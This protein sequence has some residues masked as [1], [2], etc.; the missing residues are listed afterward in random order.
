MSCQT[1]SRLAVPSLFAAFL[2]FCLVLSGHAQSSPTN[3]NKKTVGTNGQTGTPN[4]PLATSRVI[5]WTHMRGEILE[6]EDSA[7][8][9]LHLTEFL[10]KE[11][12]RYPKILSTTGEKPNLAILLQVPTNGAKIPPFQNLIKDAYD[13]E[14]QDKKRKGHLSEFYYGSGVRAGREKPIYVLPELTYGYNP[15]GM[16]VGAAEFLESGDNGQT[17]T[18]LGLSAKAEVTGRTAKLVRILDRISDDLIKED[19]VNTSQVLNEDDVDLLYGLLFFPHGIPK[20]IKDLTPADMTTL[21]TALSNIQAAYTPFDPYTTIESLSTALLEKRVQETKSDKPLLDPLTAV[22]KDRKEIRSKL[23]ND[24]VEEVQRP[25]VSLLLGDHLD[26]GDGS[27]L[28]YGASASTL[29]VYRQG[30]DHAGVT[31]LGVVQRFEDHLNG[32]PRRSAV[33]TGAALIYQDHAPYVEKDAAAD[34]SS[35][36]GPDHASSYGTDGN[37]LFG[38]TWNYKLGLEYTAPMLGLKETYAEF[39]RYRNPRSYF[40]ITLTAGKDGLRQDYVNVS[41]GQ[42]FTF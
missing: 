7:N 19:N 38:P 39:V 11:L 41:L 25:A 26:N 5:D 18:S 29:L 4:L 17:Q 32:D 33:R 12:I 28:D 16:E 8:A 9:K 36:L 1:F 22:A 31:A 21:M 40:E 2:L 20:K 27:L 37:K 30:E 13:A 34:D 6:E 23:L 24:Y 14:Q 35:T 42:S 15:Y 3:T 10:S